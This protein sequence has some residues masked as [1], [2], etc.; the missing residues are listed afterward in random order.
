MSLFNASD[1]IK[2][3]RASIAERAAVKRATAF[4]D[5]PHGKKLVAEVH[6]LQR[7]LKKT[8]SERDNLGRQKDA[9]GIEFPDC[10]SAAPKARNNRCA[11]C[12]VYRAAGPIPCQGC[13]YVG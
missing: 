2:Q 5:S 1:G 4:V 8:R 9:H 3:A 13:G 12:G 7:D 11:G 10:G 6:K